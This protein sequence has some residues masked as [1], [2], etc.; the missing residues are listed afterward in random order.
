L[1]HKVFHDSGEPIQ[2]EVAL[3]GWATSLAN[4]DEGDSTA[5]HTHSTDPLSPFQVMV[6]DEAAA[7]A[8]SPDYVT[9]PWSLDAEAAALAAVKA[10]TD[11]SSTLASGVILLTQGVIP[12]PEVDT[13]L[14]CSDMP[15]VA[16]AALLHAH[17]AESTVGVV[18]LRSTLPDR[19]T[20][21]ALGG[22]VGS[23]VR[24]S[25]AAYMR[26]NGLLPH[27]VVRGCDCT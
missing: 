5:T 3:L 27:T 14:W 13:E 10:T 7:A 23:S 22:I 20:S 17:A 8:I 9:S 12:Y 2:V 11:A 6:G 25:G 1:L 19:I 21:D 4:N 24:V 18:G 26:G 15:G 16:Q